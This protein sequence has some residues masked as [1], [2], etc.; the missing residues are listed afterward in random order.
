MK[1]KLILLTMLFIVVFTTSCWSRREI[2]DL[3]FVMGLGVSKTEDG[4][5]RV[6]AQLANPNYIVAESPEPTSIY[7]IM[8]AEGLTVFD[9]LRNLSK[10]G[11]RRLYIAHLSTIVIHEDV[12]KEGL[13]KIM[14]LFV[15]DMELRLAS[16]ILISRVPPEEI[17][18]TPNR[19]A[20][21]PAVALEIIA[22]NYGANSKIY[23]SD[24]LKAVDAASNPSMNYVTALVEK[25]SPPT[26]NEFPQLILSK[27]AVFKNDK[28]AGYLD[29]E[30]GQAYNLITNNFQIGLIVFETKDGS[31][32]IVIEVLNSEAKIT[33][34][35]INN[36]VHFDVKLEVEGSIAER[37]PL[38]LKYYQIDFNEIQEQFDIVLKDKLKRAFFIAQQHYKIDYFNFYKYFYREYPKEFKDMMDNWNNVFSNAKINIEINSKI[39]HTALNKNRGRI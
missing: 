24:L 18:D 2:E 37:M 13:R 20:A 26:K 36:Q 11:K 21:T 12:A 27:I 35:F 7:T 38:H 28:L 8:K 22:D 30:D 23:V 10:I 3:G 34:K 5:Y 32:K 15:Q 16:N 14:S 9:A 25:L 29:H 39:E 6:V 31:D 4:F 17:F 33:P 1:K 19:I